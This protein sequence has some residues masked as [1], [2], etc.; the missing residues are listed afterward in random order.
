M[1]RAVPAGGFV[2]SN[3]GFCC[4]KILKTRAFSPFQSGVT[5]I[6]TAR[7]RW[8]RPG[9]PSQEA[10]E[11]DRSASYGVRRDRFG[12]GFSKATQRFNA[13]WSS[14]VARQAHNLKVIGSNPIPATKTWY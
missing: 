14:P 8:L 5:L 3:P 11:R 4:H 1:A 9:S 6:H 7:A 12:T 2:V 13:G 10:S